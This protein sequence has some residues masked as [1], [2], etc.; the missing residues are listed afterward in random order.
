MSRMKNRKGF[1]LAEVM[2]ASMLA[3]MLLISLF[4][5]VKTGQRV[6]EQGRKQEEVKLLGDGVFEAA[7]NELQCASRIFLG[8]EEEL[9]LLVDDETMEDECAESGKAESKTLSAW[10][11]FQPDLSHHGYEILMEIWKE[12]QNWLALHVNIMDEDECVYERE[13][14]IPV[15][16][17]DFYEP[18]DI[19]GSAYVVRSDAN[20]AENEEKIWYQRAEAG[21]RKDDKTVNDE[22]K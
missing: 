18:Y 8:T 2:V 6:V 10:E 17:M 16:N 1:T 12:E 3:G 21:Y 5:L 11:T 15:L 14:W 4:P 13:E 7:A 19:E 22:R 20:M 9:K